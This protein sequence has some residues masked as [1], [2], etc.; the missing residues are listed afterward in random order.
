MIR[1]LNL[2]FCGSNIAFSKNI[3]NSDLLQLL[4]KYIYIKNNSYCIIKEENR[5]DSKRNV[6]LLFVVIVVHLLCKLKGCLIKP[7]WPAELWEC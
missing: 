6:P 1:S 3:T 4:S 5:C 2:M 7:K